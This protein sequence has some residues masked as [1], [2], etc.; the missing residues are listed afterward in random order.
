MLRHEELEALRE[1]TLKV[2]RQRG[3]VSDADVETFFAAGY[4]KR[5]LLDV[6]LGVS[7]KVMSNYV[8]HV[9]NTPVDAAFRQFDWTPPGRAAAE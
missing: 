7:H 1:F 9:A 6:I 2:V 3:A 5:H 4:T 8:N